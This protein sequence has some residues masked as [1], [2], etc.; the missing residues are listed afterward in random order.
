[1]ARRATRADLSHA[2][3]DMHIQL[4]QIRWFLFE[5]IKAEFEAEN[6]RNMREFC[7]RS[8]EN[9]APRRYTK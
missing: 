3:Q 5:I 8:R 1:M 9:A 6:M 4:R 7:K 2:L